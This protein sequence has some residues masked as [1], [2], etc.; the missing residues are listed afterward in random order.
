MRDPE[1]VEKIS[2]M[3]WNPRNHDPHSAQAVAARAAATRPVQATAVRAAATR[4]ARA[5]AP[6]TAVAFPAAPA[7]RAPQ[8]RAPSPGSGSLPSARAAAAGVRLG[9]GL[10]KPT[11]A[12]SRAAARQPEPSPAPGGGVPGAPLGRRVRLWVG[13]GKGERGEGWVWRDVGGRAEG[14]AAATA[15]V[16]TCVQPGRGAMQGAQALRSRQPDQAQPSQARGQSGGAPGAMQAGDPDLA[17][18]AGLGFSFPRRLR[19]SRS[20]KRGAPLSAL[21]MLAGLGARQ[22]TQRAPD[23]YPAA[24]PAQGRQRA[25]DPNPAAHPAQWQCFAPSAAPPA[26]AAPQAASGGQR[27]LDPNPAA[28]PAQGPAPA[29]APPAN[30]ALQAASGGLWRRVVERQW[31]CRASRGASALPKRPPGAAAQRPAAH[32]PAQQASGQQRGAPAPTP[33]PVQLRRLAPAAAYERSLDAD[34]AAAAGSARAAAANQ[35]WAQGAAQ[36]LARPLVMPGAEAARATG[37]E[38][39]R[40][41]GAEAATATGAEPARAPGVEAA[42]ATGGQPVRATGREPAR[43]KRAEPARAKGGEPVAAYERSLDA[44]A[45]AAAGSGRAAAL[46]QLWAQVAAQRLVRPPIMP[47]GEPARAPG[48]EPARAPGGEPARAPGAEP[49]R[50]TGGEPARATAAEPARATGAEPA[51]ATGGEPARATG[52]GASA[53]RMHEAAARRVAALLEE[54][55]VA[56]TA[57]APAATAAQLQQRRG[58]YM[59]AALLL[60]PCAALAGA[61]CVN[62]GALRTSAAAMQPV[63]ALLREAGVAC[64]GPAPAALAQRLQ[65]HRAAETPGVRGSAPP[66]LHQEAGLFGAV[67]AP[68]APAERLQQHRV[69]EAP[70]ERASAPPLPC[71]EAAL[72]GAGP[73]P[74]AQAV[75]LQQH[76]AAA[77]AGKRASLL[78]PLRDTAGLSRAWAALAAH[79]E[80]ASAPPPPRQEAGGVCAVLAPAPAAEQLHK[81]DAADVQS[82][83]VAAPQLLHREAGHADAGLAPVVA[84][85]RP[86]EQHDVGLEQPGTPPRLLQECVGAGPA[87]AQCADRVQEQVAR[88]LRSSASCSVF[89]EAPLRASPLQG[90]AGQGSRSDLKGSALLAAPSSEAAGAAF[91]CAVAPQEDSVARSASEGPA[92]AGSGLGGLVQLAMPRGASAEVSGG[93]KRALQHEQRPGLDSGSQGKGRR[94]RELASLLRSTQRIV[95]PARQFSARDARAQRCSVPRDMAR[96]ETP[97]PSLGPGVACAGRGSARRS[98]EEEDAPEASHGWDS[99]GAADAGCARSEHAAKR[100]RLGSGCAVKRLQGA[101]AA[102]GKPSSRTA[103]RA[104]T[105]CR[106]SSAPH[107]GKR[108]SEPLVADDSRTSDEDVGGWASAD[109]ADSWTPEGDRA[110]E[111]AAT[112]GAGADAGVTVSA[113]QGSACARAGRGSRARRPARPWWVLH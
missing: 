92:A 39:A 51:R 104:G 88:P 108:P 77:M 76:R 107:A 28:H 72:A 63:A 74:A 25:S 57:Q 58:A 109:E 79:A 16:P 56:D 12:D 22:R 18:R 52:G 41:P 32:A 10:P 4:P 11:A 5:A 103:S 47:G 33:A 6:A 110:A 94:S 29:A 89:A 49:A 1:V 99:E 43:A 95:F 98:H 112:A 111:G 100:S 26:N 61:A 42:R 50:A 62:A 113:A 82:E 2:N 90:A 7:Q 87:L 105:P 48:A 70:G 13:R 15:G 19:S 34:A 65:Q 30:A 67:P 73:A 44:A 84:P 59:Q 80:R 38:P 86:Q 36:R 60:M 17:A 55:W 20:A 54:A 69:A 93:S 106:T 101:A 64:A 35:L 45:A 24:H 14:A 81:H 68:A 23:P 3:W 102:P 21:C 8:S 85:E 75:R 53:L 66:P 9:S 91:G 40:A 46:N 31:A 97:Q 78:P 71:A 96:E 83:R 37:V 27:A